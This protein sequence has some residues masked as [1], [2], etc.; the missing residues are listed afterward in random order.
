MQFIPGHHGAMDFVGGVPSHLPPAFPVST[1]TNLPMRFLAQFECDG[2]RL[3]IGTAKFLQ[4]YQDDPEYAG[5]AVVLVEPSAPE[6]KQRLGLIQPGVLPHDIAWEY[7]DDPVE[8]TDDDVDLTR[9]KVGGT[10]YFLDAI[11]PGER[12]LLQLRQNPAKINFGG[13][14]LVLAIGEHGGI[15]GTLG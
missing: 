9:S 3:K 1:E 12:L 6:N 13:Y 15:R 11:Q 14:T 2:Q 8:A 4:I 7:H 5:E 10:C